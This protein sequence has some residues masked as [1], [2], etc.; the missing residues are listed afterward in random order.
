MFIV[1]LHS[2]NHH[3]PPSLQII[4]LKKSYNL[5]V[6]ERRQQNDRGLPAADQR[7]AKFTAGV[8]KLERLTDKQLAKNESL[9]CQKKILKKL[10]LSLILP[11]SLQSCPQMPHTKKKPTKKS[12]QNSVLE[13][14]SDVLA[15][16]TTQNYNQNLPGVVVPSSTKK[17][18]KE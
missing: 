11:I 7:R 2:R 15:H 9:N 14:Y 13:A 16:R 5:V 6:M 12:T 1:V 8:T 17:R 3:P 10:F 18:Q 4:V